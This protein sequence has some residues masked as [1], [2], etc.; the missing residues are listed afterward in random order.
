MS[1]ANPLVSICLPVYNGEEFVADTIR[2]VLD[3]SF[4]ELE[5][6]ISDNGSTDNTENICRE[7][8]SLDRRVR[9]YRC[10]VNH[11]LAWNFNNTFQMA[12]GR[13]SMWIGHDDLLD[14]SYVSRC[15]D[16]LD[17]DSGAVLAYANEKHIDERSNIIGHLE[18]R[19]DAISDRPSDRYMSI[20]RVNHWCA[21][22]SD[23]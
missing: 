20:I 5:L 16:E 17:G 14:S 8:S 3:Q 1:A 15:I 7:A 13:F 6:V 22:F 4:E 11:G 10:T 23:S 18:N 19:D 12:N 2:S 21:P 9:Y